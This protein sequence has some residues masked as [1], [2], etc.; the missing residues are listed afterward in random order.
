M[1]Q[2]IKKRMTVL[3]TSKL[4]GGYAIPP[5][6]PTRCSGREVAPPWGLNVPHALWARLPRLSQQ[7]GGLL[8]LSVRG[9]FN[10]CL[11]KQMSS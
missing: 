8:A 7:R 4:R 3:L 11:S 10:K 9:T 5:V 1:E 2:R 6:L